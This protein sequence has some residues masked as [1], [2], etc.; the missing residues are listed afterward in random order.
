MCA[1][2]TAAGRGRWPR[3]IPTANRLFRHRFWRRPPAN[4]M[5]VFQAK[6][7]G[8]RNFSMLVSHVLVP[9][10]ITAIMESPAT[11]AGLSAA[12]HVCSVMGTW[13]YE[14]LV[15]RYDVPIVVTGFEPLTCWRASAAVLQ[16][17]RRR[18]AAGERLCARRQSRGA[19]S[20]PGYAGR[21]P[22]V[23]RS[24]WRGIGVIP[25][26][27]WRL[28]ALPRFRCRGALFSLVTSARSRPLCRSGESAARIA[29]AQPVPSLWS[30]VA[31][32]ARPRCDHGVGGRRKAYYQYGRFV[33]AEERLCAMKRR[34]ASI[35]ELRRDCS[36][37][38]RRPS[39]A[40]NP[41]PSCHRR[42][43]AAQLVEIRQRAGYLP[44][45]RLHLRMERRRKRIA[46]CATS[47][48]C[49]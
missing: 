2:S 23:N 20:C 28:R 24:R 10:A 18:R 1:S 5:A 6:Q 9:P 30:A 8:L 35:V 12:G 4:A 33:Q 47:G 14:P 45:S 49:Q 36:H 43:D 15:E 17:E 39:A 21:R 3:R 31:R 29:Q 13:Q 41:R 26:S 42:A 22:A 25:Q 38:R 46:T 48:K 19:T 44:V 27:G 34:Y 40:W 32:H 11:R 37:C 16:L 7:L